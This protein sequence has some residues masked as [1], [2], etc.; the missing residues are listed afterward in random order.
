MVGESCARLAPPAWAVGGGFLPLLQ[1]QGEVRGTATF[2]PARLSPSPSPTA[3]WG[4][5]EMHRTLELEK[6]LEVAQDP[7]GEAPGRG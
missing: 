4:A 2:T 3:L 1:K 7:A 6:P 5:P